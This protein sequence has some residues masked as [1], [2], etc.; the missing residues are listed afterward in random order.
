[1]KLL[2]TIV[3]AALCL[4]R[5]VAS[6]D[7]NETFTAAV[8]TTAACVKDTSCCYSRPDCPCDVCWDSVAKKC[9]QL[10]QP[11]S[12]GTYGSAIWYNNKCWEQM[13]DLWALEGL[14]YTHKKVAGCGGDCI[15]VSTLPNLI[16][17]N[18]VCY[19]RRDSWYWCGRCYAAKKECTGC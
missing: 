18:K 6:Q 10:S 2:N 5:L 17:R 13:P 4:A 3:V 15:Q 7:D 16:V 19:Q 12:T 8:G 11:K 9:W 1:M 14:C